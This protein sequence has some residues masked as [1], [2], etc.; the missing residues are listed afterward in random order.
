MISSGAKKDLLVIQFCSALLIVS[1]QQDAISD[2]GIV[3]FKKDNKLHKINKKIDNN[4]K[5]MSKRLNLTTKA[6][7]YK[8]GIE[9]AEWLK[10]ALNSRVIKVLNNIQS[11]TLNLEMLSYW[12]MYVNFVERD[13]KVIPEFEQYLDENQYFKTLGL[14]SETNISHL[15]NELFLEAYEIIKEL[16]K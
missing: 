8:Y 3:S 9:L 13:K 14:M 16:K 4:L 11:K 12:I 2:S 15:E 10:K 6:I 1:K 5:A 7:I